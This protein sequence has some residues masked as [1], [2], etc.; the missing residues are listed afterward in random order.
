MIDG[1]L[2]HSIPLPTP[3][4]ASPSGLAISFSEAG[5]AAL[6]PNWVLSGLSSVRRTGPSGGSPTGTD[7]DTFWLD[8]EELVRAGTAV[9]GAPY[10]RTRERGPEVLTHDLG[11][12]TWQVH[13]DGRVTEFGRIDG[14][15]GARV[16]GPGRAQ[17]VERSTN[18]PDSPYSATA[19]TTVTHQ[20]LLCRQVDAHANASLFNWSQGQHLP[21]LESVTWGEAGAGSPDPDRTP[22]ARDYELAFQ[23]EARS[24]QHKVASG[25]SLL[26]VETRLSEIQLLHGASRERLR[27]YELEYRQAPPTDTSL[28]HAVWEVAADLP[29][30]S[31]PARR[32]LRRFHYHSGWAGPASTSDPATWGADFDHSIPWSAP[33][34]PVFE[35][36]PSSVPGPY[37]LGEPVWTLANLNHDGLLDLVQFRVRDEWLTPEQGGNGQYP[38]PVCADD[39]STTPSW[40]SEELGAACADFEPPFQC[41]DAQASATC[42]AVFQVQALVNVGDLRFVHDP[43]ASTVLTEYVNRAG[44]PTST[45]EDH[46][47]RI[48][49]VDLNRDGMDDVLSGT[50][51]P[52]LSDARAD[53]GGVDLAVLPAAAPVSQR[54][55]GAIPQYV[56]LNGDGLLDQLTPPQ[57]KAVPW[58]F[59]QIEAFQQVD[60]DTQFEMLEEDVLQGGLCLIAPPL[61]PVD[62]HPRWTVRWGVD[63]PEYFFEG[64][65]V[66]LELPLFGG[67][68]TDA[69]GGS[70]MNFPV[71]RVQPAFGNELLNTALAGLFGETG[72]PTAWGTPYA[73][74]WVGCT[75]DEGSGYLVLSE[76]LAWFNS[77][78]SSPWVAQTQW[79]YLAQHM[80]FTDVNGDGCADV[81]IAMETDPLLREFV[82]TGQTEFEDWLTMN[83]P[84]TT[85]GIYSEV[86]YGTCTGSFE[87]AAASQPTLGVPG[88]RYRMSDEASVDCTAQP[89]N[90][91]RIGRTCDQPNVPQPW[92]APKCA[93]DVGLL[94]S[95][96]C[97][98]CGGA[99]EICEAYVQGGYCAGGT[100]D[101]GPAPEFA[102]P[103]GA[104]GPL[105]P[106][107]D[108]SYL[109]EATAW[110]PWLRH[111]FERGLGGPGH[112]STLSPTP[113]A[114]WT[115][116]DGDGR[117]EWLNLCSRAG[118]A[119]LLA[120]T[121]PEVPG[122]PD[123]YPLAVH[124]PSSFEDFG[125]APDA[126]C[127]AGR[128]RATGVDFVGVLSGTTDVDGRVN[129]PAP[130]VGP[131]I[132]SLLV[133]LDGDSFPDHLSVENG[134]FTV[135]TQERTLPELKLVGITY[136]SGEA[137]S[138]HRTD[139]T[140][141]SL[142]EWAPTRPLDHPLLSSP[143]WGLS[144][145]IDRD[146]YRVWQRFGC[147]TGEGRFLGCQAIVGQG[148]RGAFHKALYT[149]STE[150]PG[151][152]WLDARYDETGHLLDVGLTL[153]DL[154]EA[155]HL[156]L[157]DLPYDAMEPASIG[158]CC[159]LPAERTPGSSSAPSTEGPFDPL[160]GD[161]VFLPA[162]R[163]C[164]Q[165]V[166]VA[167][168][169]FDA[170]LDSYLAS[171]A[172]LV[173]PRTGA[174]GDRLAMVRATAQEA[175]AFPYQDGLV[176][177]LVDLGVHPVGAG[178][179]ASPSD[180]RVE[181]VTWDRD[182]AQPTDH[183]ALGWASTPDD[184]LWT[185]LG[186]GAP[187]GVTR[188]R[189]VTRTV[190]GAGAHSGIETATTFTWANG[191]VVAAS[192]LGAHGEVTSTSQGL[193]AFGRPVARTDGDGVTT[194]LSYGLCGA[195][196]SVSTG[197][198]ALWTERDALCAPTLNQTSGGLDESVLY[199]G[200]GRVLRSEKDPGAN[201][202]GV[203]ARSVHDD[204]A[205]SFGL[206]PQVA[207]TDGEMARFSSWSRRGHHRSDQSCRLLD[208][209][210]LP[211]DAATLDAMVPADLLG[212]CVPDSI[213]E[214]LYGTDD[215]GR[216]RWESDLHVLADPSP[217]RWQV[218]DYDA[219]GRSVL[220][221]MALGDE[222][223]LAAGLLPVRR[224]STTEH[225]HDRTIDVLSDGRV[226]AEVRSPLRRE[227]SIDGQLLGVEEFVPTGA[228]ESFEDALGRTTVN[229]FD[230]L[231]RRVGTHH[232][233]FDGVDAA[234]NRTMLFPDTSLTLSPGGRVTRYEGPDQRG[235][236]VQY[237][238]Q[239]RVVGR[240]RVGQ[241]GTAAEYSV[242]HPTPG[243]PG[244]PI[245]QVMEVADPDGDAT[246]YVRDGMGRVVEVRHPDGTVEG[247]WFD[248]QGRLAGTVDRAG[249]STAV[250]AEDAGLGRSRFVVTHPDGSETV[251]FRAADGR[252]LRSV[253]PDGVAVDY[254]YDAW[255][256]RIREYLGA[257]DPTVDLSTWPSGELQMETVWD[258]LDR[259]VAHCPG[260]VGSPLVCT[261]Y[262]YGADGRLA[263]E[264]RDQEV[265]Q[266]A[267]RD[268]GSLDHAELM[269]P[270]MHRWVEPIYDAAGRVQG[271]A[272]NGDVAGLTWFDVAGRPT[273]YE[274]SVATTGPT[275]WIRDDLGRLSE[276]HEPGRTAPRT[277]GYWPDGQLQWTEDGDGQSNPFLPIPA[278]EWFEYDEM[279][280]LARHTDVRGTATTR[281]YDG[282]LLIGL[283]V[284]SIAG[285]PLQR[286]E[287]A[288]DTA[289]GR[290]T[291]AWS[292]LTESCVGLAGPGTPIESVCAFEE[293][294]DATFGWT[295]GGRR[296]SVT[297]ANGN[298]TSWTWDLGP[299][300]G[301]GRLLSRASETT[302]R[303]YIYDGYGRL[304]AE[305]VGDPSQPETTIDYVWDGFGQ[306]EATHWT[307]G[308]ETESEWNSYDPI[309]RRVEAEVWRNGAKVEASF[310]EYD[311]LDRVLQT[312]RV[313][314][315]ATPSFTPGSPACEPGEL[316]FEY[317]LGGQKREI[318]WPDGRLVS[319]EY[320]DGS[321][322]RVWDG[323]V[324]VS[325][326][327][328]EV[329]ARDGAGRPATTWKEGG[330]WESLTY[331]A[332]GQ[333]QSKQITM[334]QPL[335][336]ESAAAWDVF[337]D[338]G[339]DAMGRLALRET[340]DAT[341]SPLGPY[342]EL[343]VYGYN[344][345]GWLV[346]EELDGA[347]FAQTFDRVGNRLERSIDG[348]VQWTATYG[349]D[350]Q[351]V[352]REED[353]VVS[354]FSY[355]ATGRRQEGSDGTAFAYSPRG[356]LEQV[357][358]EGGVVASYGYG[359]DGMRVSEATSEG[360][361]TFMSG[362]DSWL[363]WV[364]EEN[365]QIE[366]LLNVDGGQLLSL[367]GGG[368]KATVTGPDG[369]P[370]L[371]SAED[372]SL[373][374]QGR[375]DAYGQPL[376]ADGEAPVSGFQGMLASRGDVGVL[377]AG[378]RD[379][380]PTTGTWL[381]MDPLGVDGDINSYR[382]AAGDPINM[383]D[384][385]GACVNMD[386]FWKNPVSA[387]AQRLATEMLKAPF[388]RGQID[389]KG[390]VSLQGLPV[391]QWAPD[392][393]PGYETFCPSCSEGPPI[394][395]PD[396]GSDEDDCLVE[397]GGEC[398]VSKG[399]QE[400]HEADPDSQVV[401]QLVANATPVQHTSQIYAG[402]LGGA[403]IF[404]E[405]DSGEDLF[406]G[407]ID[408][409]TMERLVERTDSE[410]SAMLS[411]LQQ[412]EWDGNSP[413]DSEAATKPAQEVE[414][415]RQE[416]VPGDVTM[417][418]DGPARFDGWAVAKSAGKTLAVGALV[419]GAVAAAPALIGT[420]AIA[421]LGYGLFGG[422]ALGAL[423]VG[424]GTTYADSLDAAKK[425]GAGHGFAAVATAGRFFGVADAYEAG[426]GRDW[427]NDR[428]LSSQERSA[429]AG[430]V[431]GGVLLSVTGPVS[432]FFS[433][434]GGAGASAIARSGDDIA[435]DIGR[436]VDD[437]A[438]G[439]AKGSRKK[440]CFIA[441]TLV[442]TAAG[443]VAI[444]DVAPGDT[445]LAREEFGEETDWRSVLATYVTE[446]RD[447]VELAIES[448]DGIEVVVT[449]PEHPFATPDGEW[450]L[451]GDL[452]P[453]E[454]LVG[455]DGDLL[456]LTAST[457]REDR[458]TVFNL[459][460]EEFHT[461]FVG[462]TGVLVHN[463]AGKTGAVCSDT[464]P[465]AAGSV[466]DSI[467]VTQ[468]AKSGTAIP[469]SFELA[470][471][472][473]S[474][475]VHPN[476][477]KHMVEYVT[478]NG[479]SHGM[480]M[481]SQGIL[482]SLRASV[483]G[484]AT[485]GVKFGEIMQVGRWELIFSEGR[486]ADALPVLKH[487]LYR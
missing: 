208:G 157:P 25:G 284:E 349:P 437:G 343:N 184:D 484:A 390:L 339:Y 141:T 247:S 81:T 122:D 85:P 245:E 288:W 362:P 282:P 148:P 289:S 61:D 11:S 462:E 225:R 22:D 9:G 268:D 468:A 470:T 335:G 102:A 337:V 373:A 95:F 176:G 34:T 271:V 399:D 147:R 467:K 16:R 281:E 434:R 485:Q 192:T 167:P 405:V 279:G 447:L 96:C 270:G 108:I 172:D 310:W 299:N 132:S 352:S 38:P 255:G 244:Q 177:G 110:N 442:L 42:N 471:A 32:R 124:F 3:G 435:D 238:G 190:R 386:A 134:A 285:V 103:D 87:P 312:G 383:A 459:E 296:S 309:G 297:D 75:T 328:Y 189:L 41:H 235:F 433:R 40:Y 118:A 355:D 465:K 363:P 375:W 366:D 71:G 372:G 480:T 197:G 457:W 165:T 161:T 264:T 62:Q 113:G 295:P 31:I 246:R 26:S 50:I 106:T 354:V 211:D 216:L 207:W 149:T 69:I 322:D 119:D 464:A 215:A 217:R 395:Q 320:Q 66:T 276:L 321:L 260:G 128:A 169:P 91:L 52:L 476:A 191:A 237:D 351:L 350:N 427:L 301:T 35:G 397:D 218:Y 340:M 55:G 8:G 401:N 154:A 65:P 416:S 336:H 287:I 280:Q 332:D 422:L 388:G 44:P 104:Q 204:R 228:L 209:V 188:P 135:R 232:P 453:G 370:L 6:G 429:A 90:G 112:A 290:I 338:Y 121:A 142:L 231:G 261:Q 193:D 252:L 258:D 473:G 449:T 396:A 139:W 185:E 181:D 68:R 80:D 361:R 353:G 469:H 240:D 439:A 153:L 129:D 450:V 223:D 357:L 12:D 227:T 486:A 333:V 1:E 319:L 15:C 28:L 202:P 305:L 140:G 371:E 120:T 46:F 200:F 380:D 83:L 45:W 36:L 187:S 206:L 430:G 458:A 59:F 173:N 444:E 418:Q 460:V 382:F 424:V 267:W 168:A 456:T 164:N 156:Q 348:L 210:S 461:Y 37:N 466:W 171:C 160:E 29:G 54:Q 146:G 259:V 311:H 474:F 253:D 170:G 414:P 391:A 43:S 174:H 254:E 448:A 111:R 402:V 117:P 381:Q 4:F 212:L 454:L 275:K 257:S 19:S 400:A 479:A 226:H 410:T 84:T 152:R 420:S 308:L 478:R 300:G 389:T 387:R 334:D 234:G 324:G 196:S 413:E 425:Q 262:A 166:P 393:V 263:T 472:G 159:S 13:L 441:G 98:D 443:L 10:F 367:V 229:T 377:S 79:D 323:Y 313:L 345:A 269:T 39:C 374:W 213:A 133:D 236:S 419:I 92:T 342:S 347:S 452:A 365:G 221:G 100:I 241:V 481:T 158:G 203:I 198:D 99:F 438:E 63:D 379:Y 21:R 385:S 243:T 175:W 303:E 70:A 67:P 2:I 278:D 136:E 248:A 194:E 27:S 105:V 359:V 151:Q 412:S 317:D 408:L 344:A 138:A 431:I 394:P 256:R 331:A 58:D 88:S 162:L 101:D 18:E 14:L 242:S 487:A 219:F 250:S 178:H 23:Y 94:S 5:S 364:V 286:S 406:D 341:T 445:V 440:A 415:A 77:E 451:A 315:Q 183:D 455:L 404:G 436:V 304:F 144:G 302:Q 49:F 137:E 179:A 463:G 428:R 51:P 298:T 72:V 64:T 283:E 126:A 195:A 56:D 475:W 127:S 130:M 293:Y 73:S 273:L 214:V 392:A 314:G 60:A 368:S 432:R 20:W 265:W 318:V 384:P 482:T 266:Y 407:P 398:A 125:V 109:A 291:Q 82:G 33:R 306:L 277:F 421:T 294:A 222:A 251:S 483:E 360:T 239:G 356:R 307:R 163:S 409:E 358:D 30:P 74:E 423:G 316:C 346:E 224:V 330:V 220:S 145:V 378:M 93:S 182:W 186:Y 86:F 369:S 47:G 131:D 292:A 446:D 249:Q 114:Q 116:T 477:T 376:Q 426:T 107:V 417:D 327:L 123:D 411:Q 115:D 205:S 53:W 24:D 17:A 329:V 180:L 274:P 326:T 233:A 155:P 78:E 325:P 89:Y 230:G 403:T 272:T 57:G 150:L 143:S 48:R 201:Q 97:S 76:R 7:A 199:D